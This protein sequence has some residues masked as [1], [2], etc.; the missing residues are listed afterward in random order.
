MLT[1]FCQ[2]TASVMGGMSLADK[3]VAGA[4]GPDWAVHLRGVP[5]DYL[6]PDALTKMRFG[7]HSHYLQ[8]W[9]SYQDVIPA[10]QFIKGVG[11]V[12][13][14]GAAT[15][16][17]AIAALAASGFS[18]VRL[19][20]SWSELDFETEQVVDAG[21]QYRRVLLAC[22]AHRL[23]P[24]I[25]CNGHHGLPVPVRAFSGLMTADAGK[26]D[27][28]ISLSTGGKIVPGLSGL[29]DL[30]EF[31]AAEVIITGA[32]NGRFTLSKPLPKALPK[33]TPLRLATLK[34]EPFGRPDEPST[35]AT[36]AGWGRYLSAVAC[37]TIDVLATASSADKGFD[38][39]I[40]NE[41]SFGSKFLAK[42]N[43]YGNT[44]TEDGG[45]PVWAAIIAETAQWHAVHKAKL[46]GVEIT[47][48]FRQHC[49]LDRGRSSACCDHRY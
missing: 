22:L 31:W 27:R 38:L 12:L 37:F 9:R 26:G 13:N 30:T 23:R 44:S 17:A 11:A 21:G 6:D 45:D 24:L 42:S 29:S 46:G 34:Y 40:W 3:I 49:P 18:T 36:L 4:E 33:G 2:S 16:D 14:Q 1:I 43:Y 35:A 25:V 10:A 19:E 7:T 41:L 32:R 20:M 8:P 5:T 39:E 15:P 48:G 47:N 28:E